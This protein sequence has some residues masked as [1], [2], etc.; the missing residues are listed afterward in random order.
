MMSNPLPLWRL[1][2]ATALAPLAVSI[3]VPNLELMAQ[4]LGSGAHSSVSFFLGAF[5]LGL[6]GTGSLSDVVGRRP[7]LRAGLIALT[8]GSAVAALAHSMPW[9][10][11]GRGAQAFG[12]AALIAVPRA[13]V[14][15][16]TDQVETPISRL[17]TLQ[18]VAPALAPLLGGVLGSWWGWRAPFL[19][20]AGLSMAILLWS[21]PLEESRVLPQPDSLPA[22]PQQASPWGQIVLLG[23]TGSA[24]SAVYFAL[25][26]AA[27]Q[28]LAPFGGGGGTIA[29]A[30][31]A[32]AAGF[33]LGNAIAPGA[34][35]QFGAS[36]ALLFATGIMVIGTLTAASGNA[37][38]LGVGLG[39]YALSAGAI[40]PM[41]I[42]QALRLAGRRAGLV[43]SVLGAMQMA[44]GAL[45][46]SW[47][48]SLSF[49]PLALGLALGATTAAVWLAIMKRRAGNQDESGHSLVLVG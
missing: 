30:L 35:R 2:A 36:S 1:G 42:A 37:T 29:L 47:V 24:A 21:F 40:M 25:L 5:A 11:V 3:H 28:V 26:A 33:V 43:T 18:S 38:V 10:W 17:A 16:L 19:A 34:R 23:I 48:L 7:V 22:P 4:A 9:L 13:M 15:D 31:G 44:L 46:A 39:I 8:L 27:P 14:K 45:C 12:A 6:L 20:L 49:A 32:M 41:T